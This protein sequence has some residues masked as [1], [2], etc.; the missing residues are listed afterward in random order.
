MDALQATKRTLMVAHAD[1]IRAACDVEDA[2]M[3]QQAG[4]A[5]NQEAI[6]AFIEKRKPDFKKL[7]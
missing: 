1:G 6:R 3:M 4:S 7:R 5:S 2:G